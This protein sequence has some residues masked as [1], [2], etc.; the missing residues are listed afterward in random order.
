MS[1]EWNA[2]PAKVPCS[3][4]KDALGL[5]TN[6]AAEWGENTGLFPE[7]PANDQLCLWYSG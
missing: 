7:P 6:A 4:C 3:L 2:H 1:D 5:T